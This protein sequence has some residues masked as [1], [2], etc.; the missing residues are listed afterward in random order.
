MHPVLLSY[1][2]KHKQQ[3]WE[4]GS[5][6]IAL[7]EIPALQ[8][9]PPSPCTRP[10]SLLHGGLGKD[11]SAQ[12]S[13]AGPYSQELAVQPGFLGDP[14][15][16]GHWRGELHSGEVLTQG[17]VASTMFGLLLSPVNG[18]NDPTPRTTSA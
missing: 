9:Q 2:K 10:L 5:L 17:T 15:F 3:Q 16:P 14:G 13:T 4:W 11:K 6:H 8:T 7:W 18:D 1:L 12:L